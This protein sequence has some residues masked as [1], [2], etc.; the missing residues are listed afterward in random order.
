MRPNTSIALSAVTA[1]GQKQADHDSHTD[2][3]SR[4]TAEVAR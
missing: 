1:D 2:Y 3:S 4:F